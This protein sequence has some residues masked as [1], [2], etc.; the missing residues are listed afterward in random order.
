MPSIADRLPARCC[1]NVRL[2]RILPTTTWLVAL[3]LLYCCDCVSTIC[4]IGERRRKSH[5]WL[6]VRETKRTHHT[7]IRAHHIQSTAAVELCIRPSVCVCPSCCSHR[8]SRLRG[9]VVCQHTHG[10]HTS[11]IV[12]CPFAGVF[13][14]KTTYTS[15]PSSSHPTHLVYSP[16]R[17]VAS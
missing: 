16:R 3:Q 13:P 5:I 7:S 15:S 1:A 2:R 8:A 9:S 11:L 17:A 10:R 4:K 12:G 6:L 14:S